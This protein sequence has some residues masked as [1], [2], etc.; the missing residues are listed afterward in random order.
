[1]IAYWMRYNENC[2]INH[3]NLERL[4]FDV[5]IV[6]LKMNK[7]RCVTLKYFNQH[8]ADEKSREKQHST[9]DKAIE[10]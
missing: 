10:Y 2:A 5:M 8:Q 1:M 6:Q 4:I 3:L 9:V 7:K